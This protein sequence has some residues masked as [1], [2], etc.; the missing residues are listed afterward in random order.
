MLPAPPTR[1]RRFRDG[2]PV[3]AFYWEWELLIPATVVEVRAGRDGDVVVVEYYWTRVGL[4]RV[5][6]GPSVGGSFAA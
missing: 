2:A 1:R 5:R 6:N 4:E 3:S